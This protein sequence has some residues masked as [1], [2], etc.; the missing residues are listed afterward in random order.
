MRFKLGFDEFLILELIYLFSKEWLGV[1][2]CRGNVWIDISFEFVFKLCVRG[3]YLENYN[4]NFGIEL[5]CKL[6]FKV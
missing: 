1:R 4:I 2:E 3:I 6:L 5:K